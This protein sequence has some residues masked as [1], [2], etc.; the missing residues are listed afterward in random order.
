MLIAMIPMIGIVQVGRQARADR[1]AYLPLVGLFIIVVWAGAE[2]CAPLKVS[3]VVSSTIIL[4]LLS[5]YASV[6]YLQI[7][8]WRNSYTLFS[9]AIQVTHR[10]AIAEGNL[11]EALSEMGKPDLALP[12]FKA[13]LEFA[14]EFSTAHYN[15]AV[16][17][18]GQN[19]LE[20]AKREYEL[21]LTY[22]ADATEAAQSHSNLGFVL[23][24]LNRPHEAIEQFTAALKINPDKQNSI[25]GRG[26]VE[27]SQNNLSAALADFTRAAQIAPMALADFWLGR[28]LEDLGQV[29]E[30]S[31][32]Y[33]AALQLNPAMTE[34]R[35]HLDEM[36]TQVH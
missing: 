4:A 31:I 11:G 1:Y 13:A 33:S 10:N 12:H 17:L 22:D 20:Q 24:Q 9:H 18:Q 23:M 21:A 27:Y 28:T 19:Q 15:V 2:L 30:A 34:A 35:Q 36:K 5:A 26:I 29:T 14:P 8:Y 16:L 6:A 7:H 25:I 32:A 3:N